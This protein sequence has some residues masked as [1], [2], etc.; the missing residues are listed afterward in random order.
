LTILAAQ[1]LPRGAFEVIVADNNSRFGLE[2]VRRVC[3]DLAPVVPAQL[4]ERPPRATPPSML[5]AAGASPS[6]TRI[7]RPP[8]STFAYDA[9]VKEWPFSADGQFREVG[10]KA[11]GGS[12]PFAKA[13]LSGIEATSSFTQVSFGAPG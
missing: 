9:G 1:T 8:P 6:P 3:N 12:S 4:R 11:R 5:R 2:E 7:S 13:A 10:K